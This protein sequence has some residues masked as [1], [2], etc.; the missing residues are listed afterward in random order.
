[1]ID[2]QIKLSV[3]WCGDQLKFT[4]KA[5]TPSPRN[6]G[7]RRG[8]FRFNSKFYTLIERRNPS[9]TCEQADE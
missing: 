4:I 1:V 9:I 2:S 5:K 6:D 8:G 3:D 7:R